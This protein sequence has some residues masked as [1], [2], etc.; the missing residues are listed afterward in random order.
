MSNDFPDLAMKTDSHS[1]SE[2]STSRDWLER[3]LP[4]AS[5]TILFIALSFAS[6]Y[7]LTVQNLSSV[8][9]QTA[10]INIIALG[11]T[12]I[13]ISGGIDLSVG[14]VMA[15]AGI[16]G[17]MLLQANV[18]L[19]PSIFGAMLAGVT[20]GLIN[21]L[22]ITLLKVSPFIATLGTMGA[23]RGLTL[24]ITNGM[25]VVRMPDSFGFLGD[26][27]VLRVVPVPL[28]ILVSL[29]LLTGFILKY[30]RLGRYAY[31]IG[32]NMEAARYAGVP[33]RFYLIVLYCFCGALTG[34]AGMI[35][36]SR[37]MTG[38]PTAGQGYELSVIA[39]VVIGGASLS[40][41]EG[42]VTGT[43]AGAFL[44]G[45]ISNGSN[46]LGISPFWQQVLIGVVIVLAVSGDELRKRRRQGQHS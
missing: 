18:P 45:L 10:V 22:L 14:S 25:P 17:T 13:M 5:V 40:G 41:G 29:A 16:C 20:W 36:S 24:V 23:A 34:L 4:F 28:A 2:Q 19:L 39:A 6:P 12:L 11:M 31:A 44:M 15:F 38:Q 37:L 32:S 42:T 7:F 8:A 27:T 35:E 26:G 1:T 33:I 3:V 46:L 9:R 30:T 21:S 43:I